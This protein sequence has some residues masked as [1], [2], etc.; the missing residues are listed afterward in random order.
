METVLRFAQHLH[1]CRQGTAI[2]LAK[3]ALDCSFLAGADMCSSG[4]M[5]PL[6]SKKPGIR[7]FNTNNI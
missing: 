3:G 1:S 2:G 7:Q 6:A 5:A 4:A